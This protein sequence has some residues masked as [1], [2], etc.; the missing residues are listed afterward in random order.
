MSART[1]VLR[2]LLLAAGL[3]LAFVIGFALRSGLAP[4]PP[5]RARRHTFRYS[6]AS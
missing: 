2:K 3:L 6:P 1:G 5:S 4:A